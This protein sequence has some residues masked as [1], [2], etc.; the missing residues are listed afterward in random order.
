MPKRKIKRHYLVGGKKTR[1]VTSSNVNPPER[2]LPIRPMDSKD[3]SFLVEETRSME[4]QRRLQE[5]QGH[6]HLARVNAK[7]HPEHEQAAAPEG[8]F[9]NDIQQNPWLDSQR[10]DG[11]DPNLNPEPPLNSAARREYDN[12]R[13]EQEMEKQLRLGNMPQ[14]SNAPKPQGP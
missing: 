13:R 3:S 2:G 5:Q 10:F 4:R 11:I 1:R 14:Y 9:Q 12:Q 6:R 8:E 7:E